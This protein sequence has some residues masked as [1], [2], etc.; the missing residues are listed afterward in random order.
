MVPGII[1]ATSR[2]NRRKWYGPTFFTAHPE[3][4]DGRKDSLLPSYRNYTSALYETA[5]YLLLN[6]KKK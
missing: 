2:G 1:H 6:N 3:T 4:G 5:R